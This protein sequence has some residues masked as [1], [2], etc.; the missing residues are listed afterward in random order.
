MFHYIFRPIKRL[1][2]ISFLLRVLNHNLMQQADWS[3]SLLSNVSYFLFMQ[4]KFISSR[5]MTFTTV[6][7][8]YVLQCIALDIIP[9]KNITVL[10][11]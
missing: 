11:K 8:I 4:S 5:D 3:K 2:E 7:N 6:L 1:F 10:G 9:M